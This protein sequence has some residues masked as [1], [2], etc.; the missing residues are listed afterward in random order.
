MQ[1]VESLFVNS[2]LSTKVVLPFS[3]IGKNYKDIIQSKIAEGI[4]G[5]CGPDGYVKPHSVEL[6]EHSSGKVD[7]DHVEFQ[8]SY[9]CD[10]CLP[11]EDMIIE[12]TTK[13]ITQKAGIH[14][15]CLLD[16]VPFVSVFISRDN[17]LDNPQFA[18]IKESN[19]VIQAKIIGVLFELNDRT[20]TVMADLL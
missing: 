2:L 11:Q 1:N 7:I 4:E 8:A 14:A 9:R 12:C 6:I 19:M 18:T 20:I 10:I 5:K 17:N 3:D 16:G 13:T 15:E